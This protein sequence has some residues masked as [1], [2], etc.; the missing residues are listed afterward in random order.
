[1]MNQHP[2][3]EPDLIL[4][5]D[6]SWRTSLKRQMK[7][8]NRIEETDPSALMNSKTEWG[9]NSVPRITIHQPVKQ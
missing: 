8:A 5:I 9:A 2:G 6:S 7:E 3:R 4:K 1:M